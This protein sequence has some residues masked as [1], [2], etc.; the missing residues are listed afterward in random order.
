MKHKSKLLKAGICIGL[1]ALMSCTAM[2]SAFA[3]AGE[4]PG[5]VD[6]KD[7]TFPDPSTFSYDDVEVNFA[8]GLQYTLHFYDANKCGKRTGRL[9]WRAD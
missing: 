3:T 9:E 1:S 7:K 5:T 2:M 4:D 6:D 8:K